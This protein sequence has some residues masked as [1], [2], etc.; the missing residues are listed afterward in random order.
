MIRDC[1]NGDEFSYIISKV[2]PKVVS[3]HPDNMFLPITPPDRAFLSFDHKSSDFDGGKIKC[4]LFSAI[5]EKGIVLSIPK[6]PETPGGG[7]P[8]SRGST[9]NLMVEM[10]FSRKGIRFCFDNDGNTPQPFGLGHE[11]VIT[12]RLK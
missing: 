1:I 6:T 12:S 11:N 9:D 10:T 5:L 2:N 4:E 3:V 7:N 8:N